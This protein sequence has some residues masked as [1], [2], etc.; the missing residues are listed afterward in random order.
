MTDQ[1]NTIDQPLT[2][3][4]AEL[5][6]RLLRVVSVFAGCFAISVY[7]AEQLYAFLVA[8]LT[9]AFLEMGLVPKMIFTALPEMF[10]THIKTA[11]F[12]SLMVCFPLFLNQFWGF[13][14]PALYA[15]EK[16]IFLPF[17]IMTPILFLCGACFAYYLVFPVAWSFFLEF[18]HV[19]ATTDIPSIQLEAKVNEYLSLTMTLLFAF[20]C[21]FLLPVLCTFMA[22]VGIIDSLWLRE[23]R[24]YAVVVTF[25]LAAILTPPDVISQILLAIPLILLYE[26]SIIITARISS[27]VKSPLRDYK[28]THA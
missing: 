21:A 1:H 24:P 18:Q 17:F 26:V 11:F 2:A 8:P 16:K 27:P 19:N 10:L 3:H 12:T 7:Y 6:S 28:K 13:V 20:G 9:A 14:A 4:I 5:R 25:I 23:K 15:S 22:K